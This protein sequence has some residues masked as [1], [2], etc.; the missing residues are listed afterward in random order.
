MPKVYTQTNAFT[1]Y[2][3]EWDFKQF[4]NDIVVISFGTNDM[5][6]AAESK[7]D[8]YIQEY[9]NFLELIRKKIQMLILFSLSV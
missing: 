6:Y 2:N 3:E 4:P 1:S 5:V 8:E 9:T 7:H